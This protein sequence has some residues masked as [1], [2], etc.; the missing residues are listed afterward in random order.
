[1]ALRFA[2]WL[3]P[4]SL[5]R[6]IML[7]FVAGTVISIIVLALLAL[8]TFGAPID[9]LARADLNAQSEDLADSLRF[10][11]EGRPTA[12]AFAEIDAGW[13][14]DLDWL[15][16]ELVDDMAYRVLDERG[17]V[18]LMSSAGAAFWQALAPARP[19]VM[20][21]LRFEHRGQTIFGWGRMVRHHDRIWY[22]QAAASRRLLEVIYRGYTL[23]LLG[24]GVVTFSVL[25]VVLFGAVG[26][27]TLRQA[28]GPLYET[29]QR[30]A[31]ISPRSLDARLPVAGV[32]T[33]IT[34]LINSFNRALDRIEQGYRAQQTFLAAAAHELKTPLALLRAQIELSGTIAERKALLADI[35]QMSR[36][37]QQLLLL[38]ETSE[39]HNY[40]ITEVDPYRVALDVRAFLQPMADAA[41]VTVDTPPPDR[42]L[43]S[44]LRWQADHSALFTLLKNLVE[45]AIQHAPRGTRIE[46]TITDDGACVRDH[47]PGVAEEHLALIFER[48][49][50]GATRRDEGAGLGL[51]ICQEIARAHGW[52]LGVSRAEPG[53]AARIRL[54]DRP[55]GARGHQGARG[56]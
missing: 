35:D 19:P 48:F 44:A 5:G 42:S 30:A 13:E 31:A 20:G 38:A 47:G 4:A 33:E 37:V 54:P 55:R 45:N 46:I 49:W 8:A 14:V 23:P 16:A 18:V 27:R 52:Q 22:L 21:Q 39:A 25:L 26:Y 6:R 28:L 36:Q 53:L 50:R 15:Y 17:T 51:A 11:A 29:S 12:I 9:L 24:I 3:R 7:A 56:P 34:P 2:P 1:M 41:G 10:D 32:P 43:T 40:E